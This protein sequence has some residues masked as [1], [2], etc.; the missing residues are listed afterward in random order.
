VEWHGLG[1]ELKPDYFL[2]MFFPDSGIGEDAMAG[3][4][5]LLG[6]E[7]TVTVAQLPPAGT[8]GLRQGSRIY[9]SDATSGGSVGAATPTGGG[10]TLIPVYWNGS[11]WVIG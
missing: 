6:G 1:G 2:E 11:A 10:A 7:R 9:V 4:S 3:A 8:P 5:D